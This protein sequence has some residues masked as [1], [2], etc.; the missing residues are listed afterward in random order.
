MVKKRSDSY[1]VGVE[2]E[3]RK[4]T[5]ID[6]SPLSSAVAW[7]KTMVTSNVKKAAMGIAPTG[8]AYSLVNAL[9]SLFNPR[10]LLNLCVV[11]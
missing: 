5:K 6:Y 3:V 4:Q 10:G 8:L 7:R 11:K 1:C 2:A 9:G